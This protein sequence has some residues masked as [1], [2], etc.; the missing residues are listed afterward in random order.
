MSERSVDDGP[1]RFK[2]V[3]LDLDDTLVVEKDAV[4]EAFV[5]TCRLASERHGADAEKLAGTVRDRARE[6]WRAAP[7]IGYSQA[8]GFSSWDGLWAKFEGDGSDL[9]QL[10]RWAPE[11]RV[12][13]WRRGLAEHGIDDERLVGEMADRFMS[14]R[15]ARNPLY[16]EAR[17][18]LEWLRPRYRLGMV[19]NGTPDTQ[20]WKIEQTDLGP[21]F[22]AVV[23]SA[24]VGAGKPDTRPFEAALRMLDCNVGEAAMVGNN[25][26]TDIAGARAAG[27]FTVWVNRGAPAA[28]DQDTG[29][30]EIAS[31]DELPRV[32]A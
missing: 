10:R 25:L 13:A 29:D 14:E 3:L 6:I 5:A 30:A 2:A 1:S 23:I 4:D 19:T 17:M 32:L 16:P 27:L 21:F 15:R 7:T 24:E 8:M 22:D 18:A 26:D 12:T 31:L 20:R 9:E 11:Y 28:P